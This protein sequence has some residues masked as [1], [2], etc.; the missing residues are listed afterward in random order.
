MEDKE[1]ME[2]ECPVCKCEYCR[3]NGYCGHM[4]G[5]MSHLCWRHGGFRFWRW[6]IG[7][8]ILVFVFTAGVKLGE[9]KSYF[10]GNFLDRSG[11]R[12]GYYMMYDGQNFTFGPG[13]NNLRANNSQTPTSSVK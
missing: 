12:Q 2:K 9:L 8:L 4:H 6:V 3:H 1:K 5:P 10:G 13:T 7:L 11:L